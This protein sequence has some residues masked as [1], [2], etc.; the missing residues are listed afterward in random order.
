MI[1]CPSLRAR[2]LLVVFFFND[3]TATDIY[4]SFPTRR[5]SDLL[6]HHP[7]VLC[8]GLGPAVDG[9]LDSGPEARDRMSTRLNSSHVKT[10]YAVSCLKKKKDAI[11]DHWRV[12]ANPLLATCA[13]GRDVE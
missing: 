1:L 7:V 4:T 13:R 3:T 11:D 10:S 5:S 6:Q 8:A 2:R 12:H 9:A